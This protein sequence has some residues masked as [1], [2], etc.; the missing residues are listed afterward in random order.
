MTIPLA[1][2]LGTPQSGPAAIV[3]MQQCLIKLIVSKL[4]AK[5]ANSPYSLKPNY[6]NW[7]RGR[8]MIIAVIL[9]FHAF[10]GTPGGSAK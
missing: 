5:V 3:G 9:N 6:V 10:M 1:V 8:L 2:R 4:K 7:L